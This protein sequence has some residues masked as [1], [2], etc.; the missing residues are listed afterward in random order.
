MNIEPQVFRLIVRLSTGQSTCVIEIRNDQTF[1]DLDLAIRRTLGHNTW[2]HCSAFFEGVPWKSRRL[3]EVYPD[4]SGPGQL[5]PIGNLPLVPGVELGYVY[6][7]GDDWQH[8]ISVEE[9]LPIDPGKE[10]PSATLLAQNS[11]AKRKKMG[12]RRRR[13][14]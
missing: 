13:D 10:Y 8:F 5:Q 2:D 9:V 11:A 12:P 1:T 6:D 7:F 3:I 14:Q 4:K